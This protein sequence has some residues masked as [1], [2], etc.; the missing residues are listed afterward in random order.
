MKGYQK[1]VMG[2]PYAV[3][4]E[5]QLTTLLIFLISQLFHNYKNTDILQY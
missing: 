3:W 2:Y 5:P 4:L 1:I